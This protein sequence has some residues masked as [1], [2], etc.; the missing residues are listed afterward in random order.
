MRP[1]WEKEDYRK[2]RS[3]PLRSQL[4]ADYQGLIS[5]DIDGDPAEGQ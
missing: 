4:K 1:N 5:S 2:G 3:E